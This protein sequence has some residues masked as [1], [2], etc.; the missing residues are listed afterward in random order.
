MPF[1]SSTAVWRTSVD[2]DGCLRHIQVDPH[3]RPLF[4]IAGPSV[5]ERLEGFHPTTYLPADCMHDFLEGCC[6]LV[7]LVLL[8]EASASRLLTV[9][10]E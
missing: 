5:I 10:D 6:P 4:G 2:H 1:S 9:R 3:H 7:L 8:K